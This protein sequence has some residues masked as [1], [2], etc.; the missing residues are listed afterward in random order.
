MSKVRSQEPAIVFFA[1]LFKEGFDIEFIKKKLLKKFG[2]ILY[3]SSAS[4]F[5]YT[6]Y[7]NKEMGSNIFRIFIFFKNKVKKN[8]LVKLKKYSDSLEL[9]YEIDGKRCVN[10]DPGLYSKENVILATNKGYTHR[11][12]IDKGVFADLTLYYKDNSYT[13]LAWTFLEYKDLKTIAMFNKLRCN[14]F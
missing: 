4:V 12:Y 6:N 14:F 2:P 10:I 5:S 1:I 8:S 11:V 9:K 3:L 7:Y 13:S